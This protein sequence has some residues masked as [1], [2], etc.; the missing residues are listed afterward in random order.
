MRRREAFY[1]YRIREGVLEDIDR[2]ITLSV[3]GARSLFP[4]SD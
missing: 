1:H 3:A 4:H 2:V